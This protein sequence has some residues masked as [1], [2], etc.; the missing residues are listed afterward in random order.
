VSLNAYKQAQ[1]RI[2]SPRAVERRLMTEITNEMMNARS[3][4]YR[5]SQLMPA[6]HRNREVWQTFSAVCGA[7]GN[8]LPAAVRAGVISLSLWVDRYT[9]DVVA[10]RESIDDLIDVNLAIIEGLGT[11]APENGKV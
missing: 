10:G 4:Q 3:A 8:K 1:A 5:G 11:S 6:L 2:E 9:S 7:P